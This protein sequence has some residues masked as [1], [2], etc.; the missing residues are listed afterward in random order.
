MG[1][2][3]EE[4]LRERIIW[5][6]RVKARFLSYVGLFGVVVFSILIM[7]FLPRWPDS[8]LYLYGAVL[9][10]LFSFIFFI[11]TRRILGSL[12]AGPS[13]QDL[14][15]YAEFLSLY[16]YPKFLFRK[17]KNPFIVPDEDVND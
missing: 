13:D 8:K 12:G 7:K 5:E 4:R 16:Y 6:L 1:K 14:A 3:K 10:E 2:K 9:M 17:K 11:Y 15:R